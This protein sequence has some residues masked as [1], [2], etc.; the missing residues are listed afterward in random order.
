MV[1]PLLA[2]LAAGA[3]KV[4]KGGG[5]RSFAKQQSDKLRNIRRRYQREADAFRKKAAGAEGDTKENYLRAAQRKEEEAE[6]YYYKNI[7]KGEKRGSEG[8]AK[9]VQKSLQDE[10]LNQ[11]GRRLLSG[12][13]VGSQF[14][15]ATKQI[16]Q[17]AKLPNGKI[18]TT[19]ANELIMEH[20][21][22]SNMMEAIQKLSDATGVDF[23]INQDTTK[24]GEQYRVNTRKGMRAIARSKR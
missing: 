7:V 1:A 13:N 9:L 16:W 15:A 22:V 23:S 2:K 12:T 18:D 11:Q 20:F 5:V 4:T 21:G 19:F 10:E 17:Q 3:S 8:A 6:K 14:Y 24:R